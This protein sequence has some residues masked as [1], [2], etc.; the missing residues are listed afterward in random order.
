MATTRTRLHELLDGIPDDRLDET[1]STL[2]TL[3]APTDDEPVTN[4]D[5]V[6][7]ART[8]EAHVHGELIPHDAVKRSLGL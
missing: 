5:R 7:L 3:G 6:A 4:E 2:R 8:H 1:E